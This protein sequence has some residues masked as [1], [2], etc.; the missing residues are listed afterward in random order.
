MTPKPRV[1]VIGDPEELR[2]ADATCE[3]VSDS[4]DVQAIVQFDDSLPS[5]TLRVGEIESIRRQRCEAGG[6]PLIVVTDSSLAVL[7]SR[8]FGSVN[9][10]AVRSC[11]ISAIAAVCSKA[12]A[13]YA[14]RQAVSSARL[15]LLLA[16]FALAF[17]LLACVGITISFGAP[18]EEFRLKRRVAALKSNEPPP[19]IRF[20]K[21]A[22]ASHLRDLHEIVASPKFAALSARDQEFIRKRV[23]EAEA[24]GSFTRRLASLVLGPEDVRTE[25]EL[26]VL[27]LELAGPLAPPD[28]YVESWRGT[29]SGIQYRFLKEAAA[30]V[31]RDR[32]AAAAWYRD[33]IRSANELLL[34]SAFD[35]HAANALL[36]EE[37]TTDNPTVFEHDLVEKARADWLIACIKLECVRNLDNALN[38]FVT[39]Y[40]MFH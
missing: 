6:F 15:R 8:G 3:Y 16:G 21:D 23:A 27:D 25:A 22:Y 11:S 26:G 24:Y 14:G 37:P 18:L 36:A 7:S 20:A 2:A 9:V 40:E 13:D 10:M 5:L 4:D 29:L 17:I 28:E 34:A 30:K 33:R 12:A 19:E 32:D 1:L 31:R 39:P 38:R 35:E